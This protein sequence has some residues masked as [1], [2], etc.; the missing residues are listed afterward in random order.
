MLGNCPYAAHMWANARWVLTH[1]LI[2][3]AQTLNVAILHIASQCE[4]CTST[5]KPLP[6]ISRKGTC[7]FEGASGLR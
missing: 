7:L 2:A 6:I 4:L 3:C 5:Q 1:R